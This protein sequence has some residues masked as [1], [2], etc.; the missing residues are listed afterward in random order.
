MPQK[1]YYIVLEVKSTAT[2]DEIKTAYRLLAKKYHPDKNIGNKASEEYFKEIQEAYAVLSNPEKRRKYDLKFSYTARPQAQQRASSPSPSYTGNAY[3]YAQQ[4]AQYRQQQPR[5]ESQKKQPEKK[6]NTESWQILVSVGIAMVLLYFII[7]YSSEKPKQEDTVSQPEVKNEQLIAEPTIGDFESPY[8]SYFGE[9]ISDPS[10]KN[11][12]SI[13]NSNFSEAVVCLIENKKEGRTIRNQYINS[14]S[15]FKMNEIPDGEYY[16]KVY[17][18]NEWDPSK[19]F[20][21]FS[22]KGG[23]KNG[24]TFAKFNT[25]KEALKMKKETTGATDSYS[26]YELKINPN[27]PEIKT[28]TAEDFFKK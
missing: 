6:D 5:E 18:G 8:S 11:S 21:N 7:S 17:F 9:E 16:V 13:M 27:A 24:N 28:I 10:S 20:S 23:F 1:N 15:V 26:T 2:F 12:I 4:Q 22:V 25:G 14:G 19:I 3:Q